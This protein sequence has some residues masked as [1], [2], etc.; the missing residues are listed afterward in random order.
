MHCPHTLQFENN[1][2]AESG[3]EDLAQRAIHEEQEHIISF[4]FAGSSACSP[5]WCYSHARM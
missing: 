1:Q 2:V 4:S 3:K 5:M